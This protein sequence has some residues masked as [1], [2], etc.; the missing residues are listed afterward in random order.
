MFF[1]DISEL[2]DTIVS[3]YGSIYEE[4]EPRLLETVFVERGEISEINFAALSDV[5]RRRDRVSKLLQHIEDGP[6]STLECFLDALTIAGYDDL[7]KE[8]CSKGGLWM[9]CTHIVIPWSCYVT[10]Y[11]TLNTL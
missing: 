9:K 10:R 8:I 6:R 5:E 7:Y 3:S 1:I 2:F 4:V 11:F